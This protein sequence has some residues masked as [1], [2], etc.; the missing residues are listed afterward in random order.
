MKTKAVLDTDK[1]IGRRVKV[2]RLDIGL[3]QGKLGNAIGV[4]F[5][6]VQK[7]EN[8]TNRIS[9]GRLQVIAKILKVPVSFFFDNDGGGHGSGSSQEMFALLE[10]A[11]ALRLMKAFARIADRRVQRST[12]ELVEGLA[13][14][15]GTSRRQAR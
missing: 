12:V 5:Q 13:E 7:Y 3:S 11:Y 2:R 6:Q 14:A 8:G 4:T 10:P 15:T 1:E 9:V